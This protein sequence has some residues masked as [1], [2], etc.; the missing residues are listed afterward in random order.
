MHPHRLLWM[1]FSVICEHSVVSNQLIG[2]C[3]FLMGCIFNFWSCFANCTIY[4]RV[5]R[6]CCMLTQDFQINK[7]AHF[8]LGAYLAFICA[9]VSRGHIPGGHFPQHRCEHKICCISTLSITQRTIL[10]SGNAVNK[11]SFSFPV[12]S[13]AYCWSSQFMIHI[14]SHTRYF[15]IICLQTMLQLVYNPCTTVYTIFAISSTLRF[16]T[17][18]P[19]STPLGLEPW[20][21]GTGCPA[22]KNS[23]NN[24]FAR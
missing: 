24:F 5:V 6:V 14:W 2:K 22:R 18:S 16:L 21:L 11:R 9:V 4:K 7:V 15:F 10:K 19:G 23:S 12:L 8:W 20:L 13:Q 17:L 3:S 1:G